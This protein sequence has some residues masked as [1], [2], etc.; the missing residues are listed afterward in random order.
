MFNPFHLIWD[1]VLA[2]RA[3]WWAV[4]LLGL[5]LLGGAW[6]VAPLKLDI[7]TQLARGRRAFVAYLTRERRHLAALVMKVVVVVVVLWSALV[8][9]NFLDAARIASQLAA[10]QRN[11]L[12]WAHMY[13]LHPKG[14][15]ESLL[16]IT[17]R[18]RLIFKDIDKKLKPSLIV[19]TFETLTEAG[20]MKDVVH[21]V[22]TTEIP[23]SPGTKYLVPAPKMTPLGARVARFLLMFDETQQLPSY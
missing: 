8:V 7:A 19:H 11:S 4:V 13:S 5:G 20:L 3:P 2:F 15:A 12:T 23:D 18:F 21:K 16:L 17:N 10:T 6:L 9:V 14:D 22:K 1:V